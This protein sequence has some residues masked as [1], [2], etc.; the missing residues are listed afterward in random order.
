MSPAPQVGC[1][2]RSRMDKLGVK[3]GM[4]VALIGVDDSDFLAELRERTPDIAKARP[5]KNS[6]LIFRRR[7]RSRSS[8][9]SA[10]Q[11]GRR[12]RSGRSGPGDRNT[13]AKG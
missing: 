13:S 12:A 10:A 11:S 3:P 7:S 1:S 8:P 4:R 2:K 6:D 9:R 5:R